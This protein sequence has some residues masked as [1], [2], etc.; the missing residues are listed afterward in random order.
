MEEIT[1]N[2]SGQQRR[3]YLIW[4]TKLPPGQKADIAQLHLLGPG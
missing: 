1:L 3:Y 2:T 4:I